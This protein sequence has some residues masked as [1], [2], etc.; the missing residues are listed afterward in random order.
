[1]AARSPRG[2]LPAPPLPRSRLGLAFRLG[3]IQLSYLPLF[4]L[5][6]LAT[7]VKGAAP[8]NTT[9]ANPQ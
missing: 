5:F 3:L 7:A 9:F 4:L 2:A 8:V 1:M 6:L